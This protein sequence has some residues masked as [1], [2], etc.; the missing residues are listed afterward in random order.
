MDKPE[1]LMLLAKTH[2]LPVNANDRLFYRKFLYRLDMFMY[3]YK[4]PRLMHIETVDENAWIVD[5]LQ[6]ISFVGTL[7]DYAK[8]R[9]DRVRLEHNSLAYYTNDIVTLEH[10]IKWV[11][12][13]TQDVSVL[14]RQIDLKSLSY[15]PGD[16]EQRNIRYRKKR[17]PH[18]HYK[19]Q[20][21]SA[22]MNYIELQD[23]LVW[24]TQDAYKGKILVDNVGHDF[25][26]Y[27]VGLWSGESLGY[28]ADEK[29]LQL[30]QF[31]LGSSIN[32][33]IEYKIKGNNTNDE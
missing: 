7:R 3:Q 6:K 17:L 1:N 4:L 30:C 33:V 28:V 14:E 29:T 26:M 27:N 23:W 20:L 16:L 21:L 25:S 32:K 31:K 18:G 5:S 24:A 19:F 8:K 11:D 10:I 9:G 2:N 22:S 13:I 12:R 15:F